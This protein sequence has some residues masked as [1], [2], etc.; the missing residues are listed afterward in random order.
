MLDWIHVTEPRP[1]NKTDD[2]GDTIVKQKKLKTNLQEVPFLYNVGYFRMCRLMA[3]YILSNDTQI[4]AAYP[5]LCFWNSILTGEDLG[6]FSIATVPI[7]S[8]FI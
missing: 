2:K 5:E 1:I 3:P 6:E 4:R 7:L 8:N